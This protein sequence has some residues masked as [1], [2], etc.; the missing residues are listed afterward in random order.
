VV[1]VEHDIDADVL[2]PLHSTADLGVVGGMLRL[3][4]DADPDGEGHGLRLGV[5]RRA[6]SRPVT[7]T[8]KAFVDIIPVS[9]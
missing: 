7:L 8:L 1:P 5:S 3:E 4:L 9:G 2:A 6:P